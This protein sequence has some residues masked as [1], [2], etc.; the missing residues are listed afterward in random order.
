MEMR[1]TKRKLKPVRRTH[2]PRQAAARTPANR[3]TA[4][5]YENKHAKKVTLPKL[6][7]C[8]GGDGRE[9]RRDNVGH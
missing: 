1:S 9:T 2:F 7:F 4:D 6:K 8:D 3:L 5:G